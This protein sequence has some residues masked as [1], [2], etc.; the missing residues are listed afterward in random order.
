MKRAIHYAMLV[1]VLAA[2]GCGGS[3][4]SSPPPVVDHQVVGAVALPA[5]TDKVY[6]VYIDDDGDSGNGYIKRYQNLCDCGE[7]V[8]YYFDGVQSGSYYL[9]ATTISEDGT[10][11]FF[12]FYDPDAIVTDPPSTPNIVVG[13]DGA[14][15]F[16][17][18]IGVL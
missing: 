14:Y 15:I 5:A 9:Y 7:F 2:Y 10:Q 1:L 8:D 18:T 13:T 6:E 11:T 4:S 17:F 16:N 3:S 12:G